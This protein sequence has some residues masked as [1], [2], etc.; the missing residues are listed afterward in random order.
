MC[1][2][3]LPFYNKEKSKL[4]STIVQTEPKLDQPYISAEA[5]DLLSKL[6]AKNPAERLGS[7]GDAEAIK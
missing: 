1:V 6:L 4:F 7:V 2:G 5:K 3:H